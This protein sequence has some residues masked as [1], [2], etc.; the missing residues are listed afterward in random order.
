VIDDD[1]GIDA[2]IQQGLQII[3]T[4]IGCSAAKRR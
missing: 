3:F 1:D 4:A 2:G